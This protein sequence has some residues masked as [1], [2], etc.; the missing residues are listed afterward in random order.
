M[1]AP[2]PPS[3]NAVP[4]TPSLASVPIA[5]LPADVLRAIFALFPLNPR[6]RI[7]SL[8]CRHWRRQ[9]LLT[10]TSLSFCHVSRVCR[11]LARDQSPLGCYVTYTNVCSLF[12]NLRSLQLLACPRA[13]TQLPSTLCDLELEGNKDLAIGP[14]LPALQSLLQVSTDM[15]DVPASARCLIASSSSLTKLRLTAVRRLSSVLASTYFPALD[16]LVA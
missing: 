12:P 6:L 5:S 9:V 14:P 7:V 15:I 13:P 4:P 10:E 11:R 3:S 16:H 1:A 2:A 8:V